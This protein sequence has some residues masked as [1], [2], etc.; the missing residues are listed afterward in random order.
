M[1][2][3]HLPIQIMDMLSDAVAVMDQNGLVVYA[4]SAFER[5]YNPLRDPEKK[6]PCLE[7]QGMN[8]RLRQKDQTFTSEQVLVPP[9]GKKIRSLFTL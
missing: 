7:L 1:D 4:N 2:I 6:M 3:P 5:L 8:L 9:V